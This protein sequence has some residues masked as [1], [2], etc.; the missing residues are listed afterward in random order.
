[1]LPLDHSYLSEIDKQTLSEDVSYESEILSRRPMVFI[2]PDDRTLPTAIGF[3]EVTEDGVSYL[4]LIVKYGSHETK[5]PP[6]HQEPRIKIRILSREAKLLRDITLGEFAAA[7]GEIFDEL[8]AA[9]W[10][11][12]KYSGRE[13][14][15]DS[16]VTVYQIEYV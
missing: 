13:F 12:K 3:A 2:R 8:S 6:T 11:E 14:S 15:G 7:Y 10:L 1:M 9:R 4:G 5:V 16:T